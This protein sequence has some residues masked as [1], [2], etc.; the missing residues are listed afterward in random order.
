MITMAES[1]VYITDETRQE[2]EDYIAKQVIPPSM[3]AVVRAAVK[4]FV[5][6]KKND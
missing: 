5:K 4:Q 2:I 6:V 3:S 1:T